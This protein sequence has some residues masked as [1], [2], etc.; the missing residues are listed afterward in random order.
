MDSAQV[1]PRCQ[2]HAFTYRNFSN[3]GLAYCG[4]KDF[5]ASFLRYKNLLSSP[6]AEGESCECT[7]RVQRKEC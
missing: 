2:A 4:R 7:S 6:S 5:R 3:E 1:F